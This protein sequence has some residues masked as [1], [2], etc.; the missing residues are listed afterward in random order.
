MT[1]PQRGAVIPKTLP[2]CN[3]VRRGPGYTPH[4]ADYPIVHAAR[5]WLAEHNQAMRRELLLLSLGYLAVAAIAAY[6]GW[7]L[8]STILVLLV[9]ATGSILGLVVVAVVAIALAI[10]GFRVRE[11]PLVS[12]ATNV[13]RAGTKRGMSMSLFEILS[14]VLR[15]ALLLLLAP[16]KA[17][18]EIRR[19]ILARSRLVQMDFEPVAA[20]LAEVVERRAGVPIDELTLKLGLAD[21][22]AT[23]EDLADI[24]G[25]V[26]LDEPDRVTLTETVQLE[27]LASVRH[28]LA[29][30]S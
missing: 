25:V 2:S 22:L 7:H 12:G 4:M 15:I 1:A 3:R 14:E 10:A 8:I 27:I 26:F 21:P 6:I 29:D 20:V 30:P 24:R 28:D 23:R 17:P 18:F 19:N 9:G 13:G 16:V 11:E 5:R